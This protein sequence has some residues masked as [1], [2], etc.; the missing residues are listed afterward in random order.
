M[1][2]L[3]IHIFHAL[4]A[5]VAIFSIS[6]SSVM[7]GEK[8][9]E[10]LVKAAFIY[11]FIKFVQWPGDMAIAQR[12]IFNICIVGRNDFG[13]ATSVFK[14]GSTSTLQ[15]RIVHKPS[16]K[17]KADDCHIL[18]ISDSEKRHLNQILSATSKAPVLTVSDIE[19]F[20]SQGGVIG[21]TTDK[22]KVRLA[23]N[24]K[25]AQAA[26]LEIDA[27]LLEIAKSVIR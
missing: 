2:R 9:K 23:I 16:W 5:S 20:V 4:I 1:W 24:T 25:S 21:F 10:Y 17:G 3:F 19:N 15:L 7:A 6:L 11:N 27:Q 18:Y 26:G 22:N 13:G 8:D 14:E 12:S